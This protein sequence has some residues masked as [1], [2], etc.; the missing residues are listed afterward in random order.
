MKEKSTGSEGGVMWVRAFH[1]P[2]KEKE[3][4]VTADAVVEIPVAR[5]EEG[6][7][8]GRVWFGIHR[9]FQVRQYEPVKLEGGFS[10]P[11]RSEEME[12]CFDTHTERLNGLMQ[13]Q[14]AELEKDIKKMRGR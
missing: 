1:K 3:F 9:T 4:R 12:E 13:A 10:M 6:E 7:E 8:P 5:F 2:R 14:F 11:C